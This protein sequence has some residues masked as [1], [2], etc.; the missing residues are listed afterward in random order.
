MIKQEA[1][2]G[3]HNH[4]RFHKIKVGLFDINGVVTLLDNII[5]DDSGITKVAYDGTKNIA[6]ILVNYDDET[7]AETII[8]KQSLIYFMDNI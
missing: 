2:S 7:F 6:A 1:I 8:D 3:F 5:I 4:L